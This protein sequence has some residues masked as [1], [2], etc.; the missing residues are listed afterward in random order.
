M[1]K[2][3]FSKELIRILNE[4]KNL[5]NKLEALKSNKINLNL[6]IDK[7]DKGYFPVKRIGKGFYGEG[8]Y[9]AC[10]KESCDYAM[11]VYGFKFWIDIYGFQH[12]YTLEQQIQEIKKECD[13]S[14]K[15]GE[16]DVGPK[17]YECDKCYD[18]NKKMWYGYF[19][20]KRLTKTLDK[21]YPFNPDHI[22]EVLEKYWKLL[23][24]N[25]VQNDIKSPNVMFD[26][27]GKIY[28]IDYGLARN[29][30]ISKNKR[31]NHMCGRVQVLLNSMFYDAKNY[32]ADPLWANN[33]DLNKYHNYVN[34]VIAARKWMKKKGLHTDCILLP[35]LDEPGLEHELILKDIIMKKLYD[36]NNLNGYTFIK[37]FS[38]Y[39]NTLIKKEKYINIGDIDFKSKYRSEI[40]SLK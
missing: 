20:T 14:K 29:K 36:N 12:L 22:T 5:N 7:V 16:I 40:K 11:K 9:K 3:K 34:S 4:R 23:D 26:D 27:E 1:D 24:N 31:D 32:G 18:T 2:E 13:L 30:Y 6:C 21:T 25:I 38:E 28:I 19:V 17:I 35:I 15:A 33:L 10:N 39:I 8:V 37:E